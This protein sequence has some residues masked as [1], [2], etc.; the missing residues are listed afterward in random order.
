MRP[1][2]RCDVPPVV[3]LTVV[4][5]PLLVRRAGSVARQGLLLEPH[6]HGECGGLIAHQQGLLGVLQDPSGHGYCVLDSTEIA[7]SP[8]VVRLAEIKPK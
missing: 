7:N 1:R 2:I 5:S 6:G 8:D 3:R 4:L